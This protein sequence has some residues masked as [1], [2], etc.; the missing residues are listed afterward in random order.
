MRTLIGGI[1]THSA[2]QIDT[3]RPRHGRK[4]RRKEPVIATSTRK[5]FPVFPRKGHK[6]SSLNRHCHNPAFRAAI[7]TPPRGLTES[8]PGGIVPGAHSGQEG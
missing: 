5:D 8:S 4:P 2:D 3:P 6:Q 1:A 7:V